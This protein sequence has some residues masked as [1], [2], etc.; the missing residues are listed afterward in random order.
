MP[1]YKDEKNKTWTVIYRFTDWKG[2][3]KQSTKRGFKTKR[4][5]LAWEQ[6]QLK[7]K[8]AE[9]ENALANLAANEIVSESLI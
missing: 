6:N 2:N 5:A 9:L 8:K 4:E 1:V 7:M 3:R